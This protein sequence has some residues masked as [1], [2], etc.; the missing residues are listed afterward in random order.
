MGNPTILAGARRWALEPLTVEDKRTIRR[1]SPAPVM[2][3]S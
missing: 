2:R 3:A 1:R